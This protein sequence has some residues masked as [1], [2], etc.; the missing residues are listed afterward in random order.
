MG[1]DPGDICFGF[2]TTELDENMLLDVLM[3][4]MWYTWLGVYKQPRCRL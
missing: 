2:L 4:S 3:N 1:H